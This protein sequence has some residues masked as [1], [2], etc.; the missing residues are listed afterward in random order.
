MK[1]KII[2][3]ILGLLFCTI[4]ILPAIQKYSDLFEIPPLEGVFIK[5]GKPMLTKETWF[6]GEYQ[7]N[8][9]KWLEENIGFRNLFVRMYNQVRYSIFKQDNSTGIFLGENGILYHNDYVDEYM[10]RTYVGHEK[11]KEAVRKMGYIQSEFEKQGKLFL[12]V[13][14]P[15]K[16]TY[17][18]EFIPEIYNL[19]EKDTNNYDVF[20]NELKLN[21]INHIDFREHF[22]K[23]KD[24]TRYPLF[25]K[26]GIHWSG[27]A[28]TFVADSL[29]NYIEA[30]S[31][32]NLIDFNC[33]PGEVTSKNLRFTDND[34]G[35][36]LNLLFDIKNYEMYYP[37]VVFIDDTGSYKPTILSIGD[38]FNQSLWGFY[39]FFPKAF[40]GNSRFWG[41]YD[42]EEWAGKRLSDVS[43]KNRNLEKELENKDIILIMSTQINISKLGYGFVE[44]AYSL[45]SINPY[46]EKQWEINAEREKKIEKYISEIK[47]NNEMLEATHKQA[48][49]RNISFMEMIR[50]NAI[51]LLEHN[52]KPENE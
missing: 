1:N 30:N 40:S 25:P 39:P 44:D 12:Y 14:A 32:F 35:K 11:I 43:V 18:P 3:Y 51:W 48:L 24:T 36:V 20:I 38:S 6:S 5:Q 15:G 9:N 17:I 45:Y 28:S 47:Q 10:G 2:K 29:F 34:L 50:L 42:V 31:E 19:H 41:Y 37:E 52:S 49:E 8:Y 33:L 23:M 16:V 13:I 7:S 22:P 26:N 27:Y 21:N 4:I 46:D